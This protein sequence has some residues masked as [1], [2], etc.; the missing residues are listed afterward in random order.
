MLFFSPASAALPRS[1]AREQVLTKFCLSCR[2]AA[3]H[4]IRHK[5]P[6][7]G[8]GVPNTVPRKFPKGGLESSGTPATQIFGGRNLRRAENATSVRR[9]FHPKS[10]DLGEDDQH[11]LEFGHA[12][13]NSADVGANSM[14]WANLRQLRSFFTT[15]GSSGA[16]SADLVRLRQIRFRAYVVE[17]GQSWPEFDQIPAKFAN[18]GASS[19]KLGRNLLKLARSRLIHGEICQRARSKVPH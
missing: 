3:L 5:Q 1:L 15:R 10:V 19:A 2:D 6:F 18:S 13:S 9:W 17:L 7:A 8:Q 11:C 12:S 14:I 4:R 16:I